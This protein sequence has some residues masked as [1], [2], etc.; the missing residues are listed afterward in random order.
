VTYVIPK[1]HENYSNQYDII[2]EP[3]DVKRVAI[4]DA[5]NDSQAWINLMWGSARD[6]ALLRKLKH[7]PTI[8]KLKSQGI[9]AHQGFIFGDRKRKVEKY[10]HWRY[11]AG[12]DFPQ[13]DLIYLNASPLGTVGDLCI[14]SK[15]SVNFDAFAFPQIIIKQSW[16]KE[17]GRFSAK[18]VRDSAKRGVA[19]SRSYVAVHASEV[20]RAHLEAAYLSY[21]SK[22]SVYFSMLTSGRMAFYRPEPLIGEILSVPLPT[23]NA[24]SLEGIKNYKDIDTKLRKAFGF[25]DAEWVLIEDLFDIT[26][27]DKL[28]MGSL[29]RQATLRKVRGGSKCEP[30]LTQYCEYFS[31]VIRA[32]FGSDLKIRATIFQEPNN[33]L[34]YRLAAFELNS[35]SAD[36]EVAI[37]DSKALLDELNK[38]N[39]RWAIARQDGEDGSAFSKRVAR[40]YHHENGKTFV[41]ILKPDAIR[42]WSRSVALQDADE[43][44]KD[45]ISWQTEVK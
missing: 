29:G 2:V 3:S 32:G 14:D 20:N 25:N 7:Y 39:R 5:I 30:Q 28:S 1:R 24:G 12:N 27:P 44:A 16:K 13:E 8:E 21:N 18:L 11:L 41:Y 36:I 10:S 37:L 22:F 26:L 35:D 40:L 9:K 17:T 6:L 31:K 33:A 34:P 42:Y 4:E 43:V 38:F 45:I 19:C 23:E 15:T